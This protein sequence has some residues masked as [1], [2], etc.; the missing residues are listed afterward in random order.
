MQL[1][2]MAK[3]AVQGCVKSSFSILGTRRLAQNRS[4]ALRPI[5]LVP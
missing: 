3:V 5:M 2:P 4:H 1:G